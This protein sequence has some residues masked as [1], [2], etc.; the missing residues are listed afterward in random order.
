MDTCSA[1]DSDK[2]R[3]CEREISDRGNVSV[4]GIRGDEREDAMWTGLWD[5]RGDQA[6][7]AWLL[8]QLRAKIEALRYFL[9]AYL[10]RQ[11]ESNSIRRTS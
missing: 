7:A 4:R 9:F 8:A 5:G 11:R 3:R 2:G 1:A 6:G 10:R